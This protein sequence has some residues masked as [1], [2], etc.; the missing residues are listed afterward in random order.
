MIPVTPDPIALQLGPL[1]VGWYGIGYVVA[2]AVMLV[3]SQRE[4]ERRGISRQHFLDAMLFVGALALIGARLYHVIHEWD[5]YRDNLLAIVLPPYSGLAL[6]GGIAGA[7]LGIVI[8]SRWKRVPTRLGLDAVIPGTLFA[9]GIARW[10]N[11]FN[12]ELYGPP[13]S[14]PWGIAIE[15]ENRIAQYPCSSLP[16][17]ATGFHPLFF[18]EFAL[19]IVG[20][21]IALYLSRRF[22]DRL[23]PGDLA[24]FWAIWYGSTRAFLET[25][26]EGYNWTL[27]GIPTAQLI[28]FVLIAIGLLWIGW[29]HRPGH[30]QQDQW[31]AAESVPDG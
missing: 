11:F 12:Q 8:Y 30:G 3:V 24:A 10:G 9:Q 2:L 20:G 21:L 7:A 25:F 17:E 18:Y 15:C 14:L 27:G 29:N 31:R 16:F 4:L 22:L 26:R 23:R 28:G 6:Y 1:S 5:A 19:N 13:T